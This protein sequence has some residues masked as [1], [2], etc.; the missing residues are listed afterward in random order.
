MLL[1]TVLVHVWWIVGEYVKL[2]DVIAVGV[3]ISVEH[4]SGLSLNR[5]VG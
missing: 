1:G 5:V 4:R 3:G 2:T